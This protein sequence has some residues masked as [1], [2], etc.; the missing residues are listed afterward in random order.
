MPQQIVDHL[1]RH[2]YGK[3]VAVLSRYFGPEHLE[4]IEDAVQDTFI[5]A[6]QAWRVG[7][8]ENPEGW[9]MRAAKNRFI[10]LLRQVKA[11]DARH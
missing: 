7:I 9:L 10:D 8:P 6:T 1:F 5:K 3:M 2:Q 11:T 4:T